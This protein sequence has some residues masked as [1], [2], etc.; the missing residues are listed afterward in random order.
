MKDTTHH[1]MHSSVNYPWKLI[2]TFL[3]KRLIDGMRSGEC[4]IPVGISEPPSA[5][6]GIILAGTRGLQQTSRYHQ[7]HKTQQEGPEVKGRM[8]TSRVGVVLRRFITVS[9]KTHC[10]DLRT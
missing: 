5:C 10:D 1:A 8:V 6:C 7:N 9:V 4:D 3:Y 2:W